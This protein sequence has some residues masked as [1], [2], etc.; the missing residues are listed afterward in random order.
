MILIMAEPSVPGSG[1]TLRQKALRSWLKE[2]P[3]V[4]LAFL[5]FGLVGSVLAG[6]AIVIVLAVPTWAANAMSLIPLGVGIAVAL[7]APL[8]VL[9]ARGILSAGRPTM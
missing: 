1:W 2:L 6:I 4:R 9:V 7:A 5:M 8:S 3:M